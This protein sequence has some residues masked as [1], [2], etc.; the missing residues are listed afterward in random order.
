LHPREQKGACSLVGGLPQI[1]QGFGSELLGI[2]TG[3]GQR[4]IRAQGDRAPN[5]AG[6]SIDPI[7]ATLDYGDD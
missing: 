5:L 2:P 6:E 7:S 3:H 4:F 1:G